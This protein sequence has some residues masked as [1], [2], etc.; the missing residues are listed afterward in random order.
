MTVKEL[1][2][3]LKTHNPSQDVTVW[4]AMQDCETTDVHLSE[5]TDGLLIAT[6]VGEAEHQ[7]EELRSFFNGLAA[8][9]GNIIEATP[10][11]IKQLHSCADNCADEHEANKAH[12]IRKEND[13]Y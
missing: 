7:H 2:E 8:V 10:E 5:T 12:S 9:F 4:D 11:E 6:D 13:G 3:N 1:I